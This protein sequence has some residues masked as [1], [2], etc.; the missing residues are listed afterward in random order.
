M[1][2]TSGWRQLGEREREMYVAACK[3]TL[4]TMNWL[5]VIWVRCGDVI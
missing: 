5:G 3:C 2:V 4:E 1:K